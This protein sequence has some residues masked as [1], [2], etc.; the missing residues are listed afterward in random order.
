MTRRVWLHVGQPKTGTTYL[1]TIA[2]AHRD[3]LLAAGLLLPGHRREH[4][5]AACAVREEPHLERRHPDAPGAWRRLVAEVAASSG[6]ALVTHEFL[7]GATLEQA[8]RAVADLEALPG[9]EVHLV[10]TTRELV[11]MVTGYWQEWVK[12]GASGPLDS[13]PPPRPDLPTWEWGWA[14]LDLAGVLDRWAGHVPAERVHVLCP[15]P[16]GVA[17]DDLWHRFAALLGVGDVDV[18]TDA[19]ESN[20]SLGVVAVELLRRVNPHV[21]VRRPADRGV[22]LRGF[23]AHDVLMPHG[24][25]PFWPSPAR[26]AELRER[27]EAAVARL[28]AGGYDVRGDVA[29]LSTPADLEPRRHPDEVEDAEILALAAVTIADLVGH[30]RD[31]AEE[32]AEAREAAGGLQ[33]GGAARRALGQALG[34]LRRG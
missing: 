2:W 12:N 27:G 22:W 34:R 20:A 33:G 18:D 21:V 14:T 10:L 15:A 19:G 29:L 30:A 23:L 28:L 5:W 4:L 17:R 32:P 6:D 1:Q 31:R 8:G 16:A 9:T 3:A 7:S 26:V 13:Y 11:A 24:G 25:D